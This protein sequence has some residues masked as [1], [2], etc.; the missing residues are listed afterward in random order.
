LLDEGAGLVP[1]GNSWSPITMEP[2]APSESSTGGRT[3]TGPEA[4]GARDRSDLLEW[5]LASSL[6][7]REGPLRVHR[8]RGCDGTVTNANW[9]EPEMPPAIADSCRCG[10][11]SCAARSC[12][13]RRRAN[14]RLELRPPGPRLRRLATQ[15]THGPRV[16]PGSSRSRAWF[17][18]CGG[19]VGGPRTSRLVRP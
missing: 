12:G 11:R 17:G 16:S 1:D 5:E 15:A 19:W 14:V 9:R 7:L 3:R 18:V 6:A 10:R 2:F 8:A 13:C 4:T